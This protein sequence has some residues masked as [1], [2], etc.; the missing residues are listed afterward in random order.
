LCAPRSPLGWGPASSLARRLL[1]VVVVPLRGGAEEYALT[2]GRAA[3]ARGWT[4]RAALPYAPGTETL[5]RDLEAAGVELTTLAVMDRL[6]PDDLE[7][8]KRAKLLAALSFMRLARRFRPDVVHIT[9]P[10]PIFGFPV[11]VSASLLGLPTLVAFQLVPDGLYVRRRRRLVYA[12]LRGRGQRWIAVSDH[13]RRLVGTMYRMDDSS[14][15]VIA[16]GAT[17]AAVSTDDDER[18]TRRLSVLAEL[19]LPADATLLLSI[20]RLHTQKGHNELV[21]AMAG[22]HAERSDVRLAIAGDGPER[23]RL[24]KLVR[25]LGLGD[26]VRLLGHR[27]DTERLMAAADLFVFPSHLEGTPFAMLEAMAQ[28]LPVVAAAFGGAEEVLEDHH[29]GILVPVGSPDSLRAAIVGA[30]ADP[31]RLAEMAARG[32][33]RVADF[34]Q[35]TMIEETIGE[36]ERLA[37]PDG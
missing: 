18:R 10:W 37:R 28:G 32:R 8:T 23:E 1:L 30:L 19:A 34:S 12:W 15:G 4:V 7:P 17:A 14:I 2:I 13:G 21:C 16:N 5:R 11:L 33:G 24:E 27:T 26:V 3:V 9:L 20:G 6:A 36:L 29:T 31:S 25:A 22:V 35:D